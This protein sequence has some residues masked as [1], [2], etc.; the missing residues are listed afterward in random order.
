LYLFISITSASHIMSLSGPLPTTTIDNL[1]TEALLI[2][3]SEGL[4]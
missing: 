2:T 3:V 4:A 1:H